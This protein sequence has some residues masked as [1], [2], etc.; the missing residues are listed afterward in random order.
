MAKPRAEGLKLDTSFSWT[1]VTCARR[2]SGLWETWNMGNG[3]PL[4][5]HVGLGMPALMGSLGLVPWGRH[6]S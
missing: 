5:P 1:E 3:A 4:G 2:S 6:L